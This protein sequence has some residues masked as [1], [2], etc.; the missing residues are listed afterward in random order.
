[1]TAPATKTTL[2]IKIKGTKGRL[3]YREVGISFNR[4]LCL[5]SWWS[6][7]AKKEEVKG[8]RRGGD[9]FSFFFSKKKKSLGRSL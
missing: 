7:G 2:T 1:M 9:S 8:R 3:G 6:L 4:S 5:F